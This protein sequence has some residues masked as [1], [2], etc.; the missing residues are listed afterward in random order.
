MIS[1]SCWGQ[2][3]V[4]FHKRFGMPAKKQEM[5][6]PFRLNIGAAVVCCTLFAP[7]AALA[8]EHYFRFAPSMDAPAPFN[9]GETRVPAARPAVAEPNSANDASGRSAEATAPTG[10]LRVKPMNFGGL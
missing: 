5:S 10:R 3:G 2:K 1:P 6:A 9:S 7:A 8:G 4:P